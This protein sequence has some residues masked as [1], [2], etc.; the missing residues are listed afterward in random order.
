MHPE[1]L[2]PATPEVIV[3]HLREQTG[4][5]GNRPVRM[6]WL[7]RKKLKLWNA[8]RGSLGR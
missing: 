6:S 3:A 2:Q 4:R 7:E 8:V 1:T 5:L